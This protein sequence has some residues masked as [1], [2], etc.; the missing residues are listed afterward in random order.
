MTR[1]ECA[2]KLLHVVRFGRDGQ[3]QPTNLGQFVGRDDDRV[4]HPYAGLTFRPDI[5]PHHAARH[6]LHANDLIGNKF[7]FLSRLVDGLAA[8]WHLRRPLLGRPAVSLTPTRTTRQANVWFHLFPLTL[9]P[10]PLLPAHN[11][12]PGANAGA[13]S[14]FL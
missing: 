2:P 7:G 8:C 5:E 11:C 14:L 12:G 9:S 10:A 4:F 13:A 3:A 6:R 1:I